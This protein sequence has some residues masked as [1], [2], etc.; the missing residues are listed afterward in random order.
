MLKKVGLVFLFFFLVKLSYGEIIYK[1][2]VSID[3]ANSKL[4]AAAT[5]SSDRPEK[6]NIYTDGLDIKAVL[7]GKEK[8]S[9]DRAVYS[10]EIS[11]GKELTVVYELVLDDY[12]SEDIITD[13]AISLIGQ[14][15]PFLDRLA[16]YKLAVEVPG[17]FILIS[18]SEE[19]SVEKKDGKAVYRFK[20]PYPLEHLHLIGTTKYIV[21]EEKFNGVLIQA[22]FFERDI[23]LADKYIQHAKK[24]IQ[25]YS[26]LIGPFPYKRFAIVENFFPT[27]Y[28][29]PTF[30]LIGQRLIRFPFILKSSFPHEIL[31]QWFGCSVYVDDESGNW[32]EGLT[33]YLSDYRFSEDKT[34]YRK[35]TILKY[36]AYA[37]EEFPLTAFRGKT[38]RRSEAI[39]YGKTM[40][41]FYMLEDIIGTENFRKVLSLIYSNFKFKRVSWGDIRAV[42]NH[43]T[44]ED[45]SWFFKQWVERKG[46]PELEIEVKD[47]T[48]KDDGFHISLSIK[49]KDKPYRLKLRVFVET[50]LGTEKY[51]FWVDRKNQEITVVSQNEPLNIVIDRD[52]QVFRDLTW[53]EVNPVIYFTLA[54]KSS[55]VYSMDKMEYVPVSGY[56]SEGVLKNPDQF[57]YSDIYNKNVVILGGDNPV[58]EK[59]FGKKLPVDTAYVEVFKNPFGDENVITVFNLKSVM[60]AKMV[61]GRIKH[62]GKYSRLVF[63][64]FRITEKSIKNYQNGIRLSVRQKA[65]IVSDTGIK[66]FDD[67]VKDALNNRI[68]YIGEQ[69]TM[70]SNHAMQL[71]IIK[72][73]YEKYPDIAIGMEMFQ[74]SKQDVLD[75]FINGEISEK[76]FLK[77]SDYYRAWKYNYNLYRPIILF[78]R[79][80][81]IRIIALN[82]DRELVKKVSD[83]GIESLSKEEQKKLPSD[84]DFVNVR[85]IEYLKSIF[86]E[87]K[88]ALKK[89]KRFINF[90]QSQ[91]IWDETM[92]ETASNFL[93]ENPDKKLI[94]L[95]GGGHIR[96]R[97]GIPSRVER[98]TGE[99]GLT[100]LMDDQLKKGIADYIVYTAHLTGEKEK[101]LGVYVEETG[102]GLK[103]VEVNKGSVA[104]KSGIKK[105]DIII[106][107]NDK[108]VKDLIDLKVELFFAQGENTV[109]VK[110]KGKLVKLKVDF[111]Q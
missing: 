45:Y 64:G 8:L 40:M 54:D 97:F 106:Q 44:G 98:R 71:N 50:Y 24:H 5:I 66:T 51:E 95:A 72:A 26:Q 11:P 37:G 62:Y 13:E 69:H 87:H 59:I 65:E 74:R 22:Y 19:T 6:I 7:F 28:S 49:Q 15:Y 43:V 79:K 57:S 33:T 88:S 21:K 86:A 29:M 70:F 55:V 35:N 93:K 38:D 18:E 85:Y 84:M 108:K 109:V 25:D 23:D 30:T 67:I 73:V 42:V 103:V 102:N 34:S 32:A 20:F 61:I 94:V 53:E 14:W 27:G 92:A 82:A 1:L 10:L 105:G 17:D 76:E 104:E 39:G 96:F 89:K 9:T 99:R 81:K 46:R 4:R 56:F 111:S 100:V 77:E 110:R 78:C 3:A 63:D 83:K 31:H 48:L 91:I 75:K 52:Y 90:L 47:H 107:F 16:V 101:K 36:L 58:V 80:N 2:D 41:V 60:Q 12:N 68:V